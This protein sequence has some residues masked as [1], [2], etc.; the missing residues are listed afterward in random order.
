MRRLSD[1]FLDDLR[2]GLL[3]PI[4]ERVKKDHTLMLAIRDGYINIY[5]RGGNILRVKERS[6]GKYKPSFDPQYNKSNRAIPTLSKD[7]KNPDDV[8]IWIRSF[9]CLKE[10]M[11][12]YFSA[13]PKPEREFQQLDARENNDSTISNESEYFISDIEVADSGLGARFDMLAIRWLASQRKKGSKCK[14]AF[15][16]MKYADGALGGSAGLLKHLNDIDGFIGNSS[17]YNELLLTMENQ[18]S[19]LD[20]LGLLKFNKGKLKATIALDANDKPEVILI[21]ANHNPRSTKLNAIFSGP[22][23]DAFAQSQ[24]FD[25]RFYVASFAGYGLHADCILT[26]SQFRKLLKSKMSE[27]GAALDGYSAALHSHQ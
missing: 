27:Q 2:N 20:Q 4:L 10:I 16:E 3:Q 9:P 12:F 17:H 19:Q 26:L 8:E 13:H 24:R 5:Y 11:D 21:L 25:F 18:F 7:I 15:I 1:N 22:Q 23:F 6:K 14:A